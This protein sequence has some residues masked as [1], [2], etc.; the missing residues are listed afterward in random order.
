MSSI[1]VNNKALSVAKKMAVCEHNEIDLL[2]T[3][4]HKFYKFFT[5]EMINYEFSSF[6]AK[7]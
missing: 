4:T 1:K 6:W 3:L 5:L 2:F 7:K